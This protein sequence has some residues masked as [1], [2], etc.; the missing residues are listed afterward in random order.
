MKNKLTEWLVKPF[1]NEVDLPIKVGDDVLMGRFKNKRVKVKSIDYNEKGD[2]QINGR[3]ALKFR[4]VKNDKKLLPTKTTNKSSTEPD[5][6]RKGVDDEYPHFKLKEEPKFQSV[7]TKSTF[8]STFGGWYTKWVPLSTK[9]IQSIIGKEKVSV[10]HVGNAEYERDVQQVARIVGKK[11]T[12]S[13][14]TSVDKGEKLAK[15]QGIQSGG[16]IIYQIE[17]TLLVAST[18]DMQ[19][20]PDK[21]GRRWIDPYWLAGDT[22]GR[23]M[24]KE[25]QSGTEKLKIDENSWDKIE[26]E[27][28]P[29]VRKETGYGDTHYDRDIYEAE[30]KKQLGP[31]KQKWIKTYIDM[32]YGII[33]K[34]KKQ[35]KKHILSQKDKKSQH[36]WN[37]ILV[38]QIKIKDIF[39]LTRADLH[40]DE[41]EKIAT[42]TVTVGSPAQFRK[43]YNERGGIINENIK[44]I[45][46]YRYN[47][48]KFSDAKK[49]KLLDLLIK[50]YKLKR[51]KDFVGGKLS[52]DVISIR[53]KALSRSEKKD[54]EKQFKL[55]LEAKRIP[56]KKG[57][58]RG[59]SSHSDLYT[60]E[61][62]K[63]TIHGLKFATVDD[64]KKSVSKIRNS[65]KTHA[66]KIQ[67]AVAMEQRAKEMGKTA[68]AAVYRAYINQMKKKT[69]KKNEQGLGS[70]KKV[71]GSDD[72][73]FGPD[74]IPTNLAQRKKMKRIHQKTSRSSRVS[75]KKNESFAAVAGA[76]YGGDIP[77]PSRKGVK[78]MKK[79]GN[80]SVPYGSGYEKIDERA[81]QAVVRGKLHKNITGFNLTYKGRKY[82]EIDFEA[83]KID[84]KTELV[85]LRILNPKKLFG[86]DLKVKFRTIS[87]GPFMKTDT[88]K[89]VNEQK[90]IKKVIAIYPGRFQ[91]FGPHHKKVFESLKSKFGEAY[92]TTSAI[93]QM[94]RHPLSFNEK[95][96]HMVKMG[97]P[98]KNIVREKVP[99]VAN[100]LLKKFDKDTTAVVYVFGAKDAGRLKGGTKKSGGKTYYQ[101]FKK[102]IN[103][104]KGFEEHGY[105]Y[106]APTVKVSGISSG[107][108]IR[109][110][111]G[112]PKIDDKK[113]EQ[114]FKK[115]FGYFDK[116]TYEMM[117]SRFGKLF[118]FYQQP[119]VKKILKEVSGFGS[120]FNA[121]DMS[122][123]GMYDFFGTLDDYFRVSPEHADILGWE[124]IGFP[125]NDTE[126]MAFTIATDD[127]EQDR[128]KTV[129]YGRTINQNRKN[130]DSVNNP[131]PKYKAEQRKNLENLTKYG[132]EIVKFFGEES[133]G[134]PGIVT[135]IK[136]VAPEKETPLEERFVEDV[137]KVFLTEGGA[138]GHMNHP[139]DD[140]NLTFSDLKNIIIIG[141]SGQL[142]RED[143]V[144]EKLDGQNLMV[145]WVDGKLKAA[146]NKGHL[147]NGGKTAPTTAGI[148]NMFSGRGEIKKAFVGA[149]RDLEKSIGSLS[150]AQ[151]KKVFGNGTKWMNLEV[152]YPQ[153]S[154]IIDY[155]VAE[156]VFHGTTE[157]DRT[158]RAKGYSKESARMLQGMIQQINQNI[159]KTFKISR[160]N[161]LKMSKV[162]NY[163]AKKSSFLG[164]LNKLQGQYGLKDTDNLG[165]YHQSFWQEYIFNAAK[166]FKVSIK[167]NQLVNLTNRW[168]FFDKS[169]SVGQIKKDFKDS[170]E[171][172]DWI[173]KTDKLD[174]NKMFKQN[175]KPFEILFFQVG[176]EILKN[177][178]G[179]L[180]VSPDAAVKKI[181]QDVDKALRDLQ[182]PD[183]VQKL[184]KLKIQIEKLEAIGGSSAIVPSEGLVFKYKG[185]IYKFTGAFAPINQILGSLR[186]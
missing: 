18:R 141:L 72:Y 106:T 10:F 104:L 98:K 155:D 156:I 152:I 107:T 16:G 148:A 79:K 4:L 3:P 65:G 34:Y 134:T 75:G 84:N 7:H 92:I 186:F 45:K 24:R 13:T 122:D 128:T 171:F 176:A 105:I 163:G 123:E 78:K 70:D 12:L 49:V 39:M 182:K 115:T 47:I 46:T 54:I 89:K 58:H 185:N 118:E 160:P 110:L 129:T 167:N 137:K 133:V 157:Y 113:R 184:N 8:N 112:S 40:K 31:Y 162:Q 22:I 57:Q 87:R 169:Y 38:N 116:S 14:F 138:Y 151:K 149:M 36:G 102:N 126:N 120:H 35:I 95:V 175:I 143:K 142:N 170:P 66:H 15:G 5:S 139:F 109:N 97:I 140:N 135:K 25:I 136:D 26:R 180:A 153:T 33:D 41:A 61:N 91:P 86:Q 20:H 96:K 183:N 99:Y 132:W 150:D 56:R 76:L 29:K 37:E 159:Q 23:K 62:P 181:K 94:P 144:S 100:N 164:R 32:C 63:G 93:Q 48:S 111:L 131:F 101:D 166:Q 50:K 83:R 177:M 64:A 60:D 173:L 17:G 85:T 82:K 51:L 69:K 42:G 114:I 67:A 124:V 28:E 165:M 52:D 178:S 88:S 121:S 19:S 55:K 147:K 2:L 130:T 68:Q 145:S 161:F 9:K 74:W 59:S 53:Q 158:G 11:G 44:H 30:L 71:V 108:E 77:S 168:A 119:Q 146:R 172:I 179:F 90:E 27:L 117:T 6:D 81:K 125:I 43:W 1:I 21:T 154:N 103:D 73:T 174:H 80:T 127:Y